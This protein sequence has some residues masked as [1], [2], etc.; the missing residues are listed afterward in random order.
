MQLKQKHACMQHAKPNRTDGARSGCESVE[1]E[2][3]L[4]YQ[5]K[6][7]GYEFESGYATGKY[8]GYE[9]ESV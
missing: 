4:R 6:Y 2:A 9:L 5:E 8:P 3:G 7:L 1:T